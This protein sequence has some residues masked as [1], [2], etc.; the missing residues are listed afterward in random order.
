MEE[1]Y[2]RNWKSGSAFKSMVWPAAV[3][4]WE[5]DRWK[6]DTAFS[7]WSANVIGKGKGPR[8]KEAEALMNLT[9]DIR[10]WF[11]GLDQ[12]KELAER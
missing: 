7:L 6:K 5:A 8:I 12:F 11:P 9:D 10:N 4:T 2:L 1:K 3:T